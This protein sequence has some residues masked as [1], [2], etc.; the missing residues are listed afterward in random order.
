MDKVVS[1]NL[2]LIRL[3]KGLAQREFAEVLN[4]SLQQI[5]KYEAGINRLSCGNLY[6]LAQ[7]LKVPIHEFFS[8]KKEIESSD[9]DQLCASMLKYFIKLKNEE[10]QRDL[11]TFVK[12]I[13]S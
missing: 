7:Y 5:Q 9:K 3:K 13:A 4:M 12:K 8:L 11:L 1:S 6:M 10:I 2:R